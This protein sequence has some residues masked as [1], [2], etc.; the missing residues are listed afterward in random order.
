MDEERAARANG[1]SVLGAGRMGMPIVGHLVKRGF[2][3]WVYDQV[4][5]RKTDVT[6][7]GARFIGTAGQALAASGTVLVCVGYEEEV[8][9]LLVGKE[10]LFKRAPSGTVFAVLS[11]VSPAAMQRMASVAEKFGIWLLDAPVCRGGNAAEGG[12]LLSLVGGPDEGVKLLTPVLQAYSSD[13]VHIGG[14]G[15]GQVAKAVNNLML[16]ACVVAS[17]EGLALG[18]RYGVDT[19]VLR[20][21]LLISSATNGALDRWGQ[22]TMAWAEDDMRIVAGM[23]TDC[24]ISL[25]QAGLNREVCRSLKL[26]RYDLECYGV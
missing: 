16:W 2:A 6:S 24:G 20:R 26:R 9:D 19:E 11:T 1:V 21:A 4:G 8:E 14:V 3:V 10:E 12:N 18:R 22:Q 7:R 13:I 17:H 23:A 5:A 15:S 25:P